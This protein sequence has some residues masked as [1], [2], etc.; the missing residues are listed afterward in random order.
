MILATATTR[1]RKEKIC[2]DEEKKKT[3][4]QDER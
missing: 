1:G 2:Q 4:E 3:K